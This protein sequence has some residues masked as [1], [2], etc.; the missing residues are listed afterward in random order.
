MPGLVEQTP[1]PFGLAVALV[2]LDLLGNP[3]LKQL[4]LQGEHLLLPFRVGVV[5]TQQVKHAVDRQQRQFLPEAGSRGAIDG[6]SR[7]TRAR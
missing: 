2:G 6:S 7:G 5:V 3:F 1:I 4:P